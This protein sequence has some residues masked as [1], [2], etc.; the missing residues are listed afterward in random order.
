MLIANKSFSNVRKLYCNSINKFKIYN[1]IRYNSNNNNNNNNNNSLYKI[2]TVNSLDLRLQKVEE[3]IKLQ[4]QKFSLFDKS[5][6]VTSI[7]DIISAFIP[8]ITIGLVSIYI[9]YDI[10]K[11]NK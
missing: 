3:Q 9:M 7:Q 5:N 2:P 4:E 1:S 6:K 8:V 10:N 11:R